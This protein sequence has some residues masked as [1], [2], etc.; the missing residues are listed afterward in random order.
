MLIFSNFI[1]LD[2][3]SIGP[4]HIPTSRPVDEIFNEDVQAADKYQQIRDDDD[5]VV[6][7]NLRGETVVIENWSESNFHQTVL[8]NIKRAKYSVPRK[9]QSYVIPLVIDGF[10]VKGHAETGSGKTAAFLLPIIDIIIRKKKSGDMVSQRSRPFALIIEPTRELAI[11][12][13]EQARK[14]SDGTVT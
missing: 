6:V 12:L 4:S 13:Y 8:N 3:V 14:L 7:S 10:D 11:Q 2:Y 9:I 5:D 1:Y